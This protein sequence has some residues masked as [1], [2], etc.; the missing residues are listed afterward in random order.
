MDKC[1]SVD[2]LARGDSWVP[3]HGWLEKPRGPNQLQGTRV[4]RNPGSCLSAFSPLLKGSGPPCTEGRVWR[5]LKAHWKSRLW[6]PWL[7]GEG[8][9]GS[10]EL[11]CSV[12][13]LDAAGMV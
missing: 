3:G 11:P 4:H 2:L 8:A 13:C 12:L 1:F 5:L 7:G 10:R 6:L 9:G